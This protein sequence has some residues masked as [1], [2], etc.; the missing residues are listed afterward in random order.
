M[1]GKLMFGTTTEEMLRDP[2]PESHK[3]LSIP[4]MVKDQHGAKDGW[5]W[6]TWVP[7]DIVPQEAQLDWPPPTN[8]PYPWMGFGSPP[9]RKIFSASSA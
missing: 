9:I 3:L 4:F 2:S 6:A 1:V 7:T 5:W 8:F